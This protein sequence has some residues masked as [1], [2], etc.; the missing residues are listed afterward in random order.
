VSGGT[1]AQALRAIDRWAAPAARAAVVE[2]SGMVASHGDLDLVGRWASITKLVTALAVLRAVEA[3]RIDLDEAAGPPGATVR[4]LLAHASGLPFDGRDPIARPGTRRIYSN[5][6]YDLLGALLEV[7]HGRPIGDVL[8]IEVLAPL[9]L[10]DSRLVGRPSQG[11]DG[12]LRDAAAFAQEL[13][14]STLISRALL[15]SATSVAF[16]GLAGVLPGIGRFDPLD[17]GLGFEI[18]DGKSPHWTGTRNSPGTYGHFG[19]SGSLLWVDP[20]AGAA[21]VVLT[22]REFGPWALEAWPALADSVLAALG[23]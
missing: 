17:W 22:D 6:G 5:P 7:R 13:L 16:P 4:H 9:D 15:A 8:T 14:R 21:L 3:H 20:V 19:G 2:A 1:V 12:S 11:I 23:A 18:R 10:A